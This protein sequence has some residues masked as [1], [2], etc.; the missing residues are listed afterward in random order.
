MSRCHASLFNTPRV[1]CRD[2]YEEVFSKL[3]LNFH[4]IPMGLRRF[5]GRAKDGCHELKWRRSSFDELDMEK[6]NAV[7]AASRAGG[8]SF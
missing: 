8:V 2:S 3:L 6:A 5:S 4:T 7:A 1:H